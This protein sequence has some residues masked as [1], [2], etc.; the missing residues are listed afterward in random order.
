MADENQSTGKVEMELWKNRELIMADKINKYNTNI[1]NLWI[2]VDNLKS[3]VGEEIDISAIQVKYDSGVGHTNV[4]DFLE[5]VKAQLSTLGNKDIDLDS[6]ILEVKDEITELGNRTINSDEISYKKYT[7]VN[8][9][10]FLDYLDAQ[11]ISANANI[12]TNKDNITTTNTSIEEAKNSIASINVQL[13][14]V[15]TSLT[16]MQEKVDSLEDIGNLTAEDIKYVNENHTDILTVNEFLNYLEELIKS[17]TANISLNKASITANKTNIDAIKETLENISA[18]DIAYNV[19][20]VTVADFL[21]YVTDTLDSL[22]TDNQASKKDIA[23]IKTAIEELKTKK[24]TASDIQ[25]ANGDYTNAKDFLDHIE[26]DKVDKEEG[27]SLIADTEI[28][29]LANVDN[30]DDT[31]LRGLIDAKSDFSGSYDDLTN[32]PTIPSI[33]G[34]ASETYVDNAVSNLVGTA[35]E[36]LDTLNELA[37]ALGD[38]PNFATTIA[39]QLGEKANRTE[40]HSH[41]NKDI[42]DTITQEKIDG[43]ESGANIDLSEYAKS[44]D[45]PT[46]VSQLLNDANYVNTTQLDEAMADI[47]LD[48]YAKLT[49]IANKFDDAQLNEAETNDTQIAIDFFSNGTL[50]TTLYLPASTGGGGGG[51]TSSYISTVLSED[52]LVGTG[53][54]FELLLDFSSPNLGK[55]TLK[56]F[57]N[58]VDSMSVPIPQGEST[59]IVPYTLFSKG[60]NK[61]V[62]YVLDRTGTMSNSLTFYVRYGSTELVTT[63]DPYSAYDY[64]SIIRYYFTPTALDTSLALTFYMKID[65][66]I[67]EGISCSSDTR[68]YF[69]FPSNLTVGKHAC[70]A[71]VEDTTG[72]KS[73][74]LV[75]NLI[76]LDDTS[77]VVASDTQSVTIEEGEQ[78]SLDYK[79]YMKDNTSFIVKAYVDD[80]LVNTGTC[81]LE[82]SYYKTS[83][84]TEGIHTVKIEVWDVTETVSDYVTWTATVTPSTYEMRTPVT[85]GAMFIASAVNHSNSD[86]NKEVWVGTNQDGTEV[87]ATLSNFAFNSENGWVDDSLIISGNSYVEV[88]IAPLSNNARY[89][90][91]LDIEF[92]SKM[93]GV[94]D[95][96]VLTLWNDTDNCGIKITTE[97]L[98]LRSKSGNECNLYFT[99]NENVSAIFVIDRDEKVAKIYIN[100]VMCEAFALSDYTANGITYL[101]DFTVNSNVFLGGLNKNGYCKIKNLRIYEIALATD[102]ILNNF[103]SNEI[104]K[105]NQRALV[106]FQNGNTLP[107]LTVYCDFSGLGKDDAKP[108]KIVYLSPDTNKYGESFTLDH[109]NSTI[110]YQGTSSMAYPIKNYKIK[111][112]DSLGKKW[113]YNPYQDGKPEST[114]TFKCDF[115]SSGHWQNTGLAKWINDNLY[116]YNASDEKSMNPMKWYS[117]NNGGYLDDTRETINGFPCRLVFINDGSTAL[118]EGQA[119]PTPGNTKDMGIFNFN[120]DK[121]CTDSFG[122]DNSIFPQCISYEV[123]ANSDTSAGAFV[124]YGNYCLD[125]GYFSNEDL[126]YSTP[127]DRNFFKGDTITFSSSST[128]IHSIQWFDSSNNS[129]MIFSNTLNIPSNC[130]KLRVRFRGDISEGININ[131]IHCSVNLIDHTGVN[132]IKNPY[133]DEAEELA[134]LQESFELRY[135]DEDDYGSD[136]GYLGL[137]ITEERILVDYTLES[138]DTLKRTTF[139]SGD[140]LTSELLVATEDG[141]DFTINCNGTAGGLGTVSG[142]SGSS[143]SLVTNTTMFQVIVNADNEYIYL[144]GIKIY[145]GEQQTEWIVKETYI[146]T[147]TEESQDYG[148]KRVVDFVG[149]STDEEFVANFEQYFNKQYVFRYYLLTVTLGMVDN[150]G[151]NM[152]IDSWDGQIWH[153]RFYDLD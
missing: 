33:D 34:L 139:I 26:T 39:T 46:R 127:F 35:P 58:D 29:R 19:T 149:S 130:V 83:S 54:N 2:E 126:Y 141:T 12:K 59:T 102:E 38:D 52:V 91:T 111:L 70:E 76:I 30:Y 11:I 119:E 73:N 148:L 42:L 37:H 150:L 7:Y 133:K 122:L 123:V 107:T 153:P 57:I 48:G 103:V 101:E 16:N 110:Q 18:S 61:L 79:V 74:I 24:I 9:K 65:G 115:M 108:C 72:T 66:V 8:V 96:E 99:D 51:A 40:L 136:Y 138:S 27:K 78:L 50:I 135:P 137:P 41:D 43:W 143:V 69:T 146:A 13:K 98:I 144:N 67:Q 116:D 85:A 23:N 1:D 3:Q 89:G 60:T 152:M 86:E 114:F 47:T 128:S 4:R 64:G 147:V 100:G 84:L 142:T 44:T 49:D 93:I 106:S 88:P 45:I 129:T 80:V 6:K 94:E 81:G 21:D 120:L 28:E 55:G 36:T 109:K 125:A 25:Y 87:T 97:K 124:P 71:W 77:L 151:K 10:E 140:Y 117:I 17:N 105:A 31:E 121:G 92:T 62:V 131:D 22:N 112:K 134:Y 5:Y 82:T 145:F 104:N 53:K 75:F 90:F 32:K 113:K 20:Y 132:E 68:G 118:N 56:V 15:Q 95:A 14:G 63:F